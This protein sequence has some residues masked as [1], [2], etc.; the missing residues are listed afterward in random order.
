MTLTHGLGRVQNVQLPGMVC[1]VDFD[2]QFLKVSP[3]CREILE[4]EVEEMEG[5]NFRDFVHPEERSWSE[6][7]EGYAKTGMI[8]HHFK[9]RHR[10]KS[11]REIKMCW[12]ATL[13]VAEKTAYMVGSLEM[14][15]ESGGV[16]EGDQEVSWIE[17]SGS[18]KVLF[19]RNPMPICLVR[20]RDL[21]I[22]EVNEAAVQHYGYE[23]Q[24]LMGME[25]EKLLEEGERFKKKLQGQVKERLWSGLRLGVWKHQ[26]K[27]TQWVD[28]DLYTSSLMYQDERAEML[29]AVD[30]TSRKM[31]ENEAQMLSEKLGS[32]LESIPDGFFVLDRNMRFIWINEIAELLFG[33]D[34]QFLLGEDLRRLVKEGEG[35]REE[36]VDLV[37]MVQEVLREGG[38][39]LNESYDRELKKWF[40][41][42][43]FPVAHGVLV[44]CRDISGRK[45]A[46]QEIQASNERFMHLVNATSDVI[47]DWDVTRD[48]LQWDDA[49]ES[50]LGWE[51]EGHVSSIDWWGAQIHPED[52]ERV[53]EGFQNSLQNR[54]KVWSAYYRLRRGDGSYAYVLDRGR[55]ILDE[56]K[57]VVRMVGGVSDLTGEYENEQKIREQ[58]ELIE[59]AT[60]AIVVMDAGWKITYWNKASEHLFGFKSEE[61]LGQE[62]LTSGD[63]KEEDVRM[64]V[65]E[66]GEW[67]GERK[68][69]C[70]NG[71]QVCVESRW[72]VLKDEHGQVKSIL[73]IQNDITQ[74]KM[75]EMHV[76]RSQRMESIGTLAGGIAHDLNNVLSPI[77]MSVELLMKEN[78]SEEETHILEVIR[79]AAQRGADLV[80]QVLT[81]ARGVDGELCALRTQDIVKDLSDFVQE[82]FPKSIRYRVQ[83]EDGMPNVLG[84]RTQLNQVFLNLCLNARDAM[85]EGGNLE[86]L[87]DVVRSEKEGERVRFRVRDTGEGMSDE[88]IQRLFEPFFTTKKLGHGSGLGLPMVLAIVR[89]HGGEIQVE[90]ELGRGSVFS[91]FLP[92]ADLAIKKEEHKGEED[93]SLGNGEFILVVDDEDAIRDIMTRVLTRAGYQVLS[94]GDVKLALELYEQHKEEIKVVVTDVMMPDTDGIGL[95]R[96]LKKRKVAVKILA[97]SGVADHNVLHKTK[98]EGAHAFLAKPASASAILRQIRNLI[99][100]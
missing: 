5:K 98:D 35:V 19:D 68:Y 86:V 96:E 97:M 91:I 27:G 59:K 15:G 70:K 31:L 45:L 44:Y 10:T 54:D 14:G 18:V 26:R 22:M 93:L 12:S 65:L 83:M 78:H 37:R 11:G 94:A 33:M 88:T 66:D 28:A 30:V 60:N 39:K 58:A 42:H 17:N 63:E 36:G 69:L 21:R 80:R 25:F 85:A 1:I 50:V 9:S 74:K 89:G 43:I 23:R 92:V 47:W 79:V 64:K 53:V 95:I 40:E 84:D 99:Q 51:L 48:L 7:L 8:M 73:V 67:D 16:S 55:V 56:E 6:D 32:V 20:L 13:S 71:E 61:M 90:S 72:T 77:W 4:Y 57:R 46:E 24:E 38:T 49:I 100:V 62:F 29:L 87:V 81:F 41:Y 2:G 82:T 52:R 75:L 76:M 34:R 3:V